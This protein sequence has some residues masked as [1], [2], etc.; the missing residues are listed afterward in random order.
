MIEV[1]APVTRPKKYPLLRII[2]IVFGIAVIVGGIA[3]IR[4]GLGELNTDPELVRLSNESDGALREANNYIA[5]AGPVFNAVLESVARDGLAAVRAQKKAGAMKAAALFDQA[6]QQLRLA[7]QKAVE[8]A[9][10]K[11]GA[12]AKQRTILEIKADACRHFAVARDL[13]RDIARMILDETI[14]TSEELV[15]KMTEAAQ[16]REKSE[17]LANEALARAEKLEAD[18]KN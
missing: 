14:K 17:A 16:L 18:S 3:Q 7:A 1:P 4:K 5:E 8:A 10:L 15:P 2:L 11:H 9:E 13:N 6:S 12:N